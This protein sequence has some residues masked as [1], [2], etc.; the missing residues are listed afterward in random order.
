M[1]IVKKNLLS[2]IFGVIAILCVVANFY[3]MGAK[4]EQLRT[5][6][7]E[8][9]SKAEALKTLLTKPR[10]MP[11]VKPGSTENEPLQGFPTK[12]AL[13][14]AH[15]ATEQVNKA[16]DTLMAKAS[17]ELNEHKPLADRALPGV[18]GETLPASA[19]A[20]LYVSMF[21]PPA[22]NGTVAVAAPVQPPP[23]G[24]K[25]LMQILSA[26]TPPNDLELTNARNE[27]ATQIQNETQRFGTNGQV[28][29]AQEVQDAVNAGVKTVTDELR[30]DRAKKCKVWVWPDAFSLYPG[31]TVAAV[32]DA[33][34]IF[35]AQIGLWTQE[36]ICK[37]IA[38]LNADS[39]SVVEAPVKMLYK[40]NFLNPNTPNSPAQVS[41]VPTFVIPNL[42]VATGVGAGGAM[43]EMPAASPDAAAA[44][45][46]MDPNAPLDKKTAY[47]PTGRISNGLFDVEHFE[48]ELVV[49]A[50][51]VPQVLEGI[52]ANRYISVIQVESIEGVDSAVFRGAGYYFGEKPCVRMRLKCEELFFRSWL[53]KYVPTRLK[54]QLQYQPPP[55]TT[56][57][58]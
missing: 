56:P 34:N 26:G 20:R 16:A 38:D 5:E 15:T 51:K 11:V 48:V 43:P 6:A 19:F 18:P 49:D 52:G 12:Q 37:G 31:M 45:P 40:I 14:A 39:P 8:H 53:Q 2:I 24:V 28:N 47:S 3:P 36:D 54:T 41:Q 50:A 21:P 46:P 57:A 58:A 27:R 9:A 10:S 35:W 1:D 55:Q 25:T 4:R 7:T 32:P 42:P 13:E 44:A 23:A 29:N 33:I 22:Q 30:A 17:T